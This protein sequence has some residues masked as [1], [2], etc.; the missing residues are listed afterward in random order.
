MIREIDTEI[1]S[2]GVVSELYADQIDGKILDI[3]GS[4]PQEKSDENKPK[5]R[6]LKDEDK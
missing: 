3:G 5:G 4:P 6:L 1:R 2:K